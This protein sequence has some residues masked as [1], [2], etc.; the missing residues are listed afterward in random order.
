MLLPH[1]AGTQ[2][3]EDLVGALRQLQPKTVGDAEC[4]L[5]AG[6]LAV[7]NTPSVLTM[8]A[9]ALNFKELVSGL[10]DLAQ[11]T[12][13]GQRTAV[14]LLVRM[15]GQGWLLLPRGIVQII[16][17]IVRGLHGNDLQWEKLPEY[18][19][20]VKFVG[21]FEKLAPP[22]GTSADDELTYAKKR[23]HV[24]LCTSIQGPD[25]LSLPLL[26]ALL[27]RTGNSQAGADI[28]VSRPLRKRW[29]E[30]AIANGPGA[31]QLR[32]KNDHRRAL[33]ERAPQERIEELKAWIDALVTECERFTGG[34]MEPLYKPFGVW[35][36]WL[37]TFERIPGPLEITR[38]MVVGDGLTQT[39]TFAQFLEDR[40]YTRAKNR[41]LPMAKM[42]KLF[43]RLR[44]EEEA[45]G[46]KF[47]NPISPQF[48]MF[49]AS[50]GETSGRTNKERVPGQGHGRTQGHAGCG[51]G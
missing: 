34:M 15:R 7:L 17:P 35:L 41:N 24:L 16:G 21:L 37:C 13:K 20:G 23:R 3:Y 19:L 48:D 18:Y 4:V 12:G 8:A 29:S 9:A 43:E 27:G 33:E 22:E 38:D 10:W 45:K 30:I 6:G 11:K 51:Q 5:A 44:I 2:K 39:N 50:P 46:R 31:L 1:S 36:N 40:G 47:L 32:A 49:R 42:H 25:D 28:A 26:R 14:N